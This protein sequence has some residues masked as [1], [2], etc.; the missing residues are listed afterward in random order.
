ML[1]AFK[2]PLLGSIVL[3]GLVFG[4]TAVYGARDA[5]P[6]TRRLVLHAADQ[7]N[8]IYL[9]AF[10]DK[11]LTMTFDDG[12]LRPL[13]FEVRAKI[14]DGCR[15]LGVETLAPIDHGT[16]AYDYSEFVLACEDGATPAIKT[17]RKGIVTVED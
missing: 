8:A 2:A 16:F 17:P 6:V 7:P 1:Q 11:Q 10:R 12:T 9:T 4:L 13:R 14:F 15:W 3:G 5:E